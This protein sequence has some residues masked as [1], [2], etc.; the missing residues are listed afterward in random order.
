MSLHNVS[1]SDAFPTNVQMPSDGD[2]ADASDLE[3]S[4]V[5]PL[6]DRTRWLYTR[7]NPFWAG[8]TVAPADEVVIDLSNGYL[9]IVGNDDWGLRIGA[10]AKL[11][12]GGR[13]GDHL[14]NGDGGYGRAN[15][16]MRVES[17]GADTTVD[18]TQHNLVHLTPT[19]A[20]RVATIAPSIT[21]VRGDACKI[22]NFSTSFTVQVN[23]PGGGAILTLSAADTNIRAWVEVVFDGTSWARSTAGS[24]F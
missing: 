9:E 2:S 11:W 10:G 23:A 4:T 19:G 21:P 13:M 6:A 16:R 12:T 14:F 5:K 17:I 20:N 22:V 7:L 3:A 8:G 15:Y 18:P 24:E 1:E